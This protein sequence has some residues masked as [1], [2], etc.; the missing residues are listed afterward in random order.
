M[1]RA[2]GASSSLT[3]DSLYS[4]DIVNWT[5]DTASAAER[6]KNSNPTDTDK[7]ID[8]KFA[9]NMA[10]FYGNY[11]RLAKTE[12]ETESAE[13]PHAEADGFMSEPALQPQNDT[14]TITEQERK[15][16]NGE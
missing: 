4:V 5:Y 2:V 10:T 13:S 11:Y 8:A 1:D 7:A 15:P 3:K 6:D 12:P 16:T 14:N 9:R